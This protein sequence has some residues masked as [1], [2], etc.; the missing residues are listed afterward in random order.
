M[1]HRI[2]VGLVAAT[3][4]VA[5]SSPAWAGDSVQYTYDARG[6]LV[7]VLHSSTSTVNQN[8]QAC[9]KYDKE[10]NRVKVATT[11][12]STSSPGACPT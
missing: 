11:A 5:C 12:A 2:R 4:G 10:G 3:L 8:V 9:Y 1:S 7:K 6:R